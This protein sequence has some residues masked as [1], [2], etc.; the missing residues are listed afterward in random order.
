MTSPHSTCVQIRQFLEE[1]IRSSIVTLPSSELVDHIAGCALCRGALMLLVAAGTGMPIAPAPITCEETQK[2]LA[3]YIEAET[4]EGSEAA[5]RAYPQVWWHFWSC[6]T[7][8]ETYR[9]IRVLEEAGQVRKLA[10]PVVLETAKNHRPRFLPPIRLTRVFLNYAFPMPSSLLGSARGLE[11][12]GT[13]LITEEVSGYHISL[14][15]Q[16][17]TDDKWQVTVIAVPPVAGMLLLTFGERVFRARF[18]AEGVARVSDV[19][20]SL[21]SATDGYDLV[22]GIELDAEAP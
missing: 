15:V 22:V 20:A 4:E 2:S 19:P 6:P 17:Q 14:S 16:K 3:P 12:D 18:T 21:F 10:R 8:S 1:G 13:V 7:C 9:L 11:D 5:M